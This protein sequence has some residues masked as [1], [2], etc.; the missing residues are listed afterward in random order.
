LGEVVDV[1]QY[2]SPKFKVL[3]PEYSRGKK[4][5]VFKGGRASTKSW[6]IA[7]ALIDHAC[8]YDGLRVVCGREIMKSIADSSKK[9]LEDTITRAGKWGEFK[10]TAS[11]IENTRTR[12]RFTF[13]GLRDNPDSVKG[14]EGADIFWGDEADSFSQESLDILCP[15]MR[16]RGC[17]VILS[18]NPQLPTTP[19]EKLQLEKANRTVTVF[20]NY[21]EVLEYLPREVIDE[22]EEC[23][24]KEP[25]KYR[26]IWLG[27]YRMQTQDT[28]VP[29]KYVTEAWARPARRSDDGLVA[30]LDIGLFHDR[31]VMVIRQGPNVVYARE[32]KNVDNLELCQQVIG[33][34]ARWKVQRL[35]VDSA[36]QGYAVYQNLKKELDDCVVQVNAGVVAKNQKK[37]VRL[38]DEGWGLVRE[39][40]KDGS[41]GGQGRLEEWVTD[42]TN[43]KYFYD[44]K[45]RYSIESKRS[46]IGR[47]FPSTDWAD[48]LAYSL[49]VR[50]TSSSSDFARPESPDGVLFRRERND[51]YPSDWMG[52]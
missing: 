51:Y 27:E 3:Y 7:R 21:L 32:W 15:T 44:T 37:Y 2:T 9:L 40:L 24:E 4:Y 34:V 29:L 39:W 38:R 28:F 13:M 18:Y 10:T 11:Y 20:I 8:T 50:P 1:I 36:G 26:W 45:G 6:S 48:A 46:Y 19:V 31:S 30:G 5:L 42:L 43:I 22:A 41:L 16:K 35:A 52:I 47:G 25:E 12:A 49:L 33:L 14:L 23:R 17:K